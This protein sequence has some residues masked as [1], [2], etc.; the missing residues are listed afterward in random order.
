MTKY[1]FAT[2]NV[3]FAFAMGNKNAGSEAK[4]MKKILEEANEGKTPSKIFK[5][6]LTGK[7]DGEYLQARAKNVM[8]KIVDDIAN[9][10]I[11]AIGLQELNENDTFGHGHILTELKKRLLEKGQGG[12]YDSHERI[13]LAPGKEPQY[14]IQRVTD[15]S[16]DAKY[17][18]ISLTVEVQLKPFPIKPTIALIYD[19]K[20]FGKPEQIECRD[21]TGIPGNTG[22]PMLGVRTAKGFVL[23]VMH[24]PN[25][26]PFLGNALKSTDFNSYQL[27][28]LNN[29]YMKQGELPPDLKEKIETKIKNGFMDPMEEQIKNFINAIKMGNESEKLVLMGDMN[30]TD[31]GEEKSGAPASLSN[32]LKENVGLEFSVPEHGTCCYNWDSSNSPIKGNP[33][34]WLIGNNSHF[35]DKINNKAIEPF[36]TQVKPEDREKNIKGH[37]KAILDEK[38]RLKNYDFKGDLIYYSKNLE[39]VEVNGEKQREL[40]PQTDKERELTSQYSDHVFQVITLKEN[41]ASVGGGRRRTLKKKRKKTRK[42]KHKRKITKRKKMKKRR[43]RKHRS[44]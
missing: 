16:G 4:W 19:M 22:R 34:R 27:H 5:E 37:V 10:N 3:S 24:A 14:G 32:W 30:D 12:V 2:A 18:M 26:N 41:S 42:H 9:G 39:P 8:G 6:N 11:D 21:F 1:N 43:S 35:D 13:I 25:V 40:F 28:L 29:Y 7:T 36:Y 17:C 33:T 38:A 44:R 20:K 23:M 31:P 15:V